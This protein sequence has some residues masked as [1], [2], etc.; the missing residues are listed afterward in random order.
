MKVG[1]GGDWMMVVE[2]EIGRANESTSGLVRLVQ[3]VVQKREEEVVVVVDASAVVAIV[4]LLPMAVCLLTK[5]P[6]AAHASADSSQLCN[7]DM[8]A[9]L[10]DSLA[11]YPHPHQ[12]L[13]ARPRVKLKHERPALSLEELSA[14]QVLIPGPCPTG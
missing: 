4:G 5:Q 12:L 14:A 8:S 7:E 9:T 13:D 1:T 10:I 6:S 3:S 2:G 11:A